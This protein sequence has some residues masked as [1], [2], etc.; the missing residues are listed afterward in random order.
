MAE[1]VE[2]FREPVRTPIARVSR[3]FGVAHMMIAVGLFAVL[4]CLLELFDVPS[5]PLAVFAYVP[6]VL[7]CVAIPLG[8]VFLYK[9]RHP[10]SLHWFLPP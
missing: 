5:S 8:Q 3:R 1:N 9:G 6:C 2:R 10:R 7:F 4:F